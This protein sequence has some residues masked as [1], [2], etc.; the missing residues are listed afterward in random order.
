MVNAIL[1]KNGLVMDGTGKPAF[2]ADVLIHNDRIEDIGNFQ[3]KEADIVIDANGLVIAPGFIDVH[4]HLD[5]ILP[6]PRHVHILETW[7]RQGVT[8]IV[9]GNCGYSPAPINHDYVEDISIYWNFALPYDGLQFQWTTMAEFLEFLEKMGQTLNVAILTGHNTLR[10]NVMGFEA[11]FV[12]ED[13]ISEMKLMLKRSVEAGSFGLSL[14]LEYVPGIFSNTDEILELASVL[15]KYSLPLVPHTRALLSKLYTKAVDEVI[16]IAEKNKIP[17]HISH[18]AGGG[19]GRAR[20]L[21]LRA[22]QEAIDR[23][24]KISHDNLP[25][26]NT[27]TTAL[28]EFPPW[29]FDGGIQKFFERLKG[30]PQV[31]TQ[32]ILEMEKFIPKWPPWENKYWTGRG[33]NANAVLAG[34]RIKENKIFENWNIKDIAEEL[35]KAPIDALIDLVIEE[36]GKIYLITGQFGNPV[37]EDF[38]CSL[39]S[40]PNCSIGTDIVAADF[41]TISPVAYGA[42]TKVLGNIARDKG[43]MTQEEAVRKMTSLPAKQMQ[44]KDRGILQKSAFADITIFNPKTV[45]NRASYTNPYQPSEGIEY[46]LINGKLVLEKDK[47]Y[48]KELAGKVLRSNL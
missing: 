30:D 22:I 29:L 37:A 42:F 41:K 15:T 16:L 33:F 3:G 46:V 12:K 44:I 27:S 4:S 11:R 26:P 21:A 40:D 5:F 28:S 20:K 48:S 39:L 18:H 25:W 23:G 17:L 10:T 8:T 45:N 2:K 7:I 32:A 38:V 19:I 47:F 31:R 9:G 36:H 35:H 24:V 43:I 34:F 6:S 1:I 13:E 14:G